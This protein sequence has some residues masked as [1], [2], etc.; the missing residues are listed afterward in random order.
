MLIAPYICCCPMRLSPIPDAHFQIWDPCFMAGCCGLFQLCQF[1]LLQVCTPCHSN[2]LPIKV[3]SRALIN[4]IQPPNVSFFS[5]LRF[6]VACGFHW[7][8]KISSKSKV[9][10]GQRWEERVSLYPQ[11]LGGRC[12]DEL[13]LHV[14]HRRSPSVGNS[15]GPWGLFGFPY[16]LMS[17]GAEMMLHSLCWKESVML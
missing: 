1:L 12:L 3:S 16:S 14:L 8:D 10:H 13:F 4:R 2:K 6:P 17:W 5:V 15:P 11:E 7:E 9:L